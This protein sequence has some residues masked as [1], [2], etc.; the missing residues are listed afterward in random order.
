MPGFETQRAQHHSWPLQDKARITQTESSCRMR[1]LSE[2]N[3]TVVQGLCLVTSDQLT[4]LSLP[5]ELLAASRLRE[6]Q[7][8]S[9]CAVIGEITHL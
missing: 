7:L 6:L 9:H 1:Q 2:S 3:R 8:E 4:P 5:T